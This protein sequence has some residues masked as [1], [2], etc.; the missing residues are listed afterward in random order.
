[1]SQTLAAAPLAPLSPN[2][3]MT[4][5]HYFQPLQE[6]AVVRNGCAP[7]ADNSGAM[8]RAFEP[9]QRKTRPL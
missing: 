7:G 6:G 3:V 2:A 1:M 8:M 4:A 5:F 9:R